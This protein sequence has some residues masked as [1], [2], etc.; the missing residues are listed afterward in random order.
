MITESAMP[1][2]IDNGEKRAVIR[3]LVYDSENMYWKRVDELIVQ[4]SAL[5][6]LI[7]KPK[8]SSV[9]MCKMMKI[10]QKLVNF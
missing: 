5:V 3:C 7:K 10:V 4:H 2:E 6:K 9:I 1:R 8:L